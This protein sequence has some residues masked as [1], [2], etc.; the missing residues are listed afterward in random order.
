MLLSAR[1]RYVGFSSGVSRKAVVNPYH[2]SYAPVSV[3][4]SELHSLS[5]DGPTDDTATS[6]TT[7]SSSASVSPS[8]CVLYFHCKNHLHSFA[9]NSH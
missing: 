1:D 3:Q 9:A 5:S 6:Q 4:D 7:D 8:L 2:V